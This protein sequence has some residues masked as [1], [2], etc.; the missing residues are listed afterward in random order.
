MITEYPPGTTDVTILSDI[1]TE[2]TV[3]DRVIDDLLEEILK[4]VKINNAYNAILHNETLTEE[5]LEV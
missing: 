2:S 3:S 4:E 5:D 1:S